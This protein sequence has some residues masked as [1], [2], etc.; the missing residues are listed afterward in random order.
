MPF[1]NKLVKGQLVRLGKKCFF[2]FVI[3]L[4]VQSS[5]RRTF[6]SPN[7]K[8]LLETYNFDESRIV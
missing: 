4:I 3:L 1:V 2:Y 7:F 6:D 8:D 5:K